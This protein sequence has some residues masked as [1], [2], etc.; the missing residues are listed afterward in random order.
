R[1]RGHGSAASAKTP[2]IDVGA[3]LKALRTLR[4]LSQRDLAA[5]SGVTNGMISMIEQN[6]HSPSV[7]TLNRITDALGVSFGEFFA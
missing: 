6:K 1:A 4:N 3:R 7:A 2:K 5:S